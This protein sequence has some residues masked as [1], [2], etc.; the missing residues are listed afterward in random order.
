MDVPVQ[1]SIE[2]LIYQ[3]EAKYGLTDDNLYKTLQCESKL[4]PNA[5]GDYATTT[6]GYVPT[7]FGVAQIHLPAHKDIT[8]EE[9]LDPTFAIDWA[10]SE[11]AAG[12]AYEWTCYRNMFG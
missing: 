12:R 10:A 2:D 6:A 5:R 8:K 11:F 1:P 4:N 9:A 3:A 7:S